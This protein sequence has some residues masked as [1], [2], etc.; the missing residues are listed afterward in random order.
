MDHEL[1]TT[2]QG[3]TYVVS[4]CPVVEPGR[5]AVGH[6]SKRKKEKA[7]IGKIIYLER[8]KIQIG[9]VK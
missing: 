5:R 2:E 7:W 4:S 8:G 9:I 3:S 6:N 1:D